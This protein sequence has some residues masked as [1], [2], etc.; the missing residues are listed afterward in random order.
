M[1][2]QLPDEIKVKVAEYVAR[3]PFRKDQFLEKFKQRGY[4]VSE[5][6]DP[7]N[8]IQ[9][10]IA[11]FTAGIPE[12]ASYGLVDLDNYGKDAGT[13]D[14][15]LIG[16]VQPA[17]E[18]G[19]LL[20][21]MVSGAALWK[22]GM[23]AGIPAGKRV[24]ESLLKQGISG[25][26]AGVVGKV[27]E[28]AA[29][30]S[31]ETIVGALAQTY[32]ADDI[33]ELD[34]AL[35]EWMALGVGSELLSRKVLAYF[36]RRQIPAVGDSRDNMAGEGNALREEVKTELENQM[37]LDAP[38][39]S[40][41]EI[42][43]NTDAYGESMVPGVP[44]D[45]EDMPIDV[46]ALDDP[47]RITPTITDREAV[48]QM[49]DANKDIIQKHN[50]ASGRVDDTP[51]PDSNVLSPK[52]GWTFGDDSIKYPVD[53]Y[54]K[55]DRDM[56]VGSWDGDI[57]LNET[58]KLKDNLVG[59]VRVAMD[60]RK[61]VFIDKDNLKSLYD[62]PDSYKNP[63]GGVYGVAGG[64]DTIDDLRSFVIAHEIEHFNHDYFKWK[65]W[66]GTSKDAKKTLERAESL[67][68]DD[69]VLD[70]S[71]VGYENWVNKRALDI[72]AK[73]KEKNK[74]VESTDPKESVENFE[75]AEG[76]R[77]HNKFAENLDKKLGYDMP[78][79][80][81]DLRKMAYDLG[82]PRKNWKKKDLQEYIRK[83]QPEAESLDTGMSEN[84]PFKHTPT[85]AGGD[86]PA[87]GEQREKISALVNDL[88][89]EDVNNEIHSLAFLPEE[90]NVKDANKLIDD[91]ASNVETAKTR[92]A[93][94]AYNDIE[95]M[96]VKAN[97]G[98]YDSD[99][100]N[101]PLQEYADELIPED[102][103]RKA[104]G[105]LHTLFRK[106]WVPTSQLLG[107]GS[108]PMSAMAIRNTVR[109]T[110]EKQSMEGK[111]MDYVANGDT[112]ENIEE[113]IKGTPHNANV[114]DQIAGKVQ[115]EAK[116][117][118]TKKL[119]YDFFNLVEDMNNGTP[120]AS[121]I[122]AYP[123]LANNPNI[124]QAIDMHLRLTNSIADALGLGKNKRISYYIPHVFADKSGEYVAASVGNTMDKSAAR[125]LKAMMDDFGASEVMENPT[126]PSRGFRHLRKREAKLD[127]FEHD[128]QQV[129]SM[130]IRGA[131]AKITN[132][133]IADHGRSAML[134]LVN[135]GNQDIAED[136]SKY[137]RYA[138]GMPTDFRQKVAHIFSD[139]H[140]FNSTVDRLV[141][142]IGGKDA[143]ILQRARMNPN[144]SEIMFEARKWLNELDD[145]TRLRDRVTGD[146]NEKAALKKIRGVLAKRVND[147]RNAANNPY[148]AAATS[149]FLY[150]T[151]I[152]AK[153][154]LNIAHGMLNQTQI[155]TNVLP[156]LK[157]KNVAW[158]YAHSAFNVGKDKRLNGRTVSDLIAESGISKDVSRQQEFLDGP[159]GALKYA[160]DKMMFIAKYSEE[161]NRETTLLG[162]Y[163]EYTEQGVSHGAAMHKARQL[164][165]ETHFSFTRAGTAPI[166][167]SPVGR[168]F[169][170][171]KSYPMHQTDFTLNLISKALTK[172]PNQK[173][174]RAA[175]VK[176]TMAYA[177]MIGGGAYALPETN[178]PSRTT[179]PAYDIPMN[180]AED[181]GRYGLPGSVVK[182]LMGPFGDTMTKVTGMLA[183]L[184][185]GGMDDA[186]HKALRAVQSF[187]VPATVRRL[188]GEE[189]DTGDLLK[190]K[191]YDWLYFTGL[192]KYDPSEGRKSRATG[193]VN[194][195]QSLG[196]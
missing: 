141:G 163:K 25:K 35:A 104:R 144:D 178:I 157:A 190:G 155:L 44:P 177:A 123:S 179:P 166:L 14:V 126:A 93:S 72:R 189:I 64:F 83:N 23:R 174:D 2:N 184:I 169:L 33:S 109:L 111:W 150:R 171:F 149:N 97:S 61:V 113:L 172:G 74:T 75:F 70:T 136:L 128:Y 84:L 146:K 92:R 103:Q 176:H 45:F 147:T 165:E 106:F 191:K 16:E 110:V 173:Q 183:S 135:E 41:Q 27:A 151:Q 137:L 164:V 114:L 192:K 32:R 17:R 54:T 68:I 77:N 37:D 140:V 49:E 88:R 1:A 142:F 129:M 65:N 105:P 134:K 175:L 26:T 159:A 58:V 112:L 78:T 138:M 153:L 40:A 52:R 143:E 53:D 102:V 81:A 63:A 170:M 36:K 122:K 50:Q 48:R 55:I 116:N 86:S 99:A 101:P 181:S 154:G 100:S 51:L 130:Y 34:N 180:M 31:P 3:R 20:G 7:T 194:P 117:Q 121:A 87:T 145:M 162:A 89:R 10:N 196:L 185:D 182:N 119:F 67:G 120:R 85:T 56:G 133:K 5:F 60:G 13:V 156:M 125:R 69:H 108:H 195:L 12:G 47:D 46:R 22:T 158:G 15:P 24:V 43:S 131:A 148:M 91:L 21:G 42:L 139:S 59:T 94:Q 152:V 8:T 9:D 18:A 30:A 161:V 188:Y 11:A 187:A 124:N 76:N 118:D 28:V 160:Q 38:D 168:L 107:F 167:R 90:I 62:N 73:A 6:E 98:T 96:A 80:M 29:A 66:Y 115:R 79:S 186:N 39:G 132:D 127:H 19:R 71:R 95:Q 57:Y 82:A 193:G 4:D